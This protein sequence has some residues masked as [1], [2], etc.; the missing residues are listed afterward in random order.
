MVKRIA[1][2][3]VGLALGILVSVKTPASDEAPDS[4][5][6]VHEWGTFTSVAGNDG[7][8]VE[9]LPLASRNDLP[10]FVN[11]SQ[12]HLKDYLGGTVRMETPV[13]Y[14]YTSREMEVSA[15]VR[16]RRGWITEWYP[17]AK[18]DNHYTWELET[19]STLEWKDVKVLPNATPSFPVE[20]APSHYY[21]ARQ[22]DAAPLRI[23]DQNEKFLFYR[24]VGGFPVPIRATVQDDG[25]IQLRSTSDVPLNGVILFESRGGKLGYRVVDSL[26]GSVTINPPTLDGDLVSLQGELER[27]LVTAGLYPKEAA[28]MVATWRDSWFEEGTRV[29]YIVPP[30]L[31]DENLPLKIEPK[32]AQVTRAFVG[33]MEVITATTERA[34]ANAIQ[35]NDKSALDTYS[36]FLRPIV[37]RLA[38]KSVADSEDQKRLD[39]LSSELSG[40]VVTKYDAN[41]ACKR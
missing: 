36:R 16:F 5:L 41:T 22:T 17:E 32:P 27:I 23:K 19:P 15:T 39:G 3:V 40:V 21:A 6:A 1:P 35:T 24:G 12:A 18:S 33:R 2:I 8:A 31:I 25:R 38:A 7:E 34:V 29:F 11:Y 30:A 4:R 10:C 37:E 20:S 9:W 26:T 28:A 13:L 14:F